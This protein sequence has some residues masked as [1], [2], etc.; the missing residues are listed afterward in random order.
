MIK[1]SKVPSPQVLNQNAAAWTAALLEALAR[2]DAPTKAL[3]SR[4]N[5]PSIKAALVSE[6]HGKC[7]YCESKLRH[8]TY[9]DI[10]HIIPKSVAPARWFDWQNLTL[11]CDKCNTNKSDN[12]GIIDP[13]LAD[14][15][16]HLWFIGALVFPRP[17]SDSGR[18]TE[19]ILELNRPELLER[20][21]EKLK[22]LLTQLELINR[23][24]NEAI[25]AALKTDILE[26]IRDD[27]E[28][29]GLARELV[30]TAR[31]RGDIPAD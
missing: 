8:V 3:K 13:Y 17:G 30:R 14:P 2:G 18:I 10:E 22:G 21:Q 31:A 15:T 26:E 6:T 24:Q 20:R 1:L 16:D 5:E 23:T 11:A 12:E 7:A 25:K 9:G 28:F 4:Y 29:A 27:R 19:R